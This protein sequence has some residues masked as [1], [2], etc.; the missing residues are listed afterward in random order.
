MG[1]SSDASWIVWILIYFIAYFTIVFFINIAN[2]SLGLSQSS[3]SVHDPGFGSNGN[4]PQNQQIK[5]FNQTL[6][7]DQGF[8]TTLGNIFD[9]FIDTVRFMFG[10]NSSLGSSFGTATFVFVLFL[11]YIPLLMLILAIV[12]MV[13]I[14]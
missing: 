8:F 7:P 9:V 6:A 2:T 5:N 11:T 1:K 14:G 13:L 12:G 10:F 3:I 4:N